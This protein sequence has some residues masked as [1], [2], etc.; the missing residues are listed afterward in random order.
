VSVIP[1]KRVVI[2]PLSGSL[3]FAA[4]TYGSLDTPRLDGK[5]SGTVRDVSREYTESALPAEDL[6]E[7]IWP[8]GIGACQLDNYA[9]NGELGRQ[10]KAELARGPA[11]L[12]QE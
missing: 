1:A 5:K 7:K 3:I 11:P 9:G 12:G 2:A 8:D 4:Q 10:R 6:L